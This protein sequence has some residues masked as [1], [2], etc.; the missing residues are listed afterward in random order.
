MNI[1][2]ET[3]E[4]IDELNERDENFDPYSSKKID[5]A[6]NDNFKSNKNLKEKLKKTSKNGYNIESNIVNKNLY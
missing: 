3:E 5:I 1:P 6:N 2:E 4:E